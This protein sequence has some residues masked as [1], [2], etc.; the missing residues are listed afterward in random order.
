MTRP[1]RAR[2]GRRARRCRRTACLADAYRLAPA[3]APATPNPITCTP[4]RATARPSTQHRPRGLPG[5]GR[6]ERY[7][8]PGRL[9]ATT[10]LTSQPRSR[11]QTSTSSR[12]TTHDWTAWRK[13]PDGT[14]DSASSG[15]ASPAAVNQPPGD[16]MKTDVREFIRRLE[17]VGLTVEPTP[18]HYRVLRGGN[19]S[20]KRTGC[21]S[22]CPARPTRSAGGGPRSWNCASSASASSDGSVTRPGS[23]RTPSVGHAAIWRVS[24]SERADP[25]RERSLALRGS[26]PPSPRG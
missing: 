4:R 9:S 23:G 11:S 13:K 20:G 7:G 2:S 12:T 16:R 8:G 19:P 3:P 22:R 10:T 6:S 1:R 26:Y 17:A 5:G 15:A 24:S 18:G 14:G 21:R 25:R